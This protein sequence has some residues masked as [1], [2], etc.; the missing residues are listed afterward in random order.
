MSYKMGQERNN[1]KRVL[2]LETKV[3]FISFRGTVIELGKQRLLKV[4]Y[5]WKFE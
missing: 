2:Y 1:L 4:L 5:V 3:V